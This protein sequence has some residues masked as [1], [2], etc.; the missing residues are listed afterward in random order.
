MLDDL[1]KVAIKE[2]IEND[3]QV[4]VDMTFKGL[5]SAAFLLSRIAK[6][7]NEDQRHDAINGMEA[8]VSA[9]IY[10][11]LMNGTVM[12]IKKIQDKDND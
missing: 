12:S 2:I 11:G 3:R 1:N 10:L 8:L 9:A 4:E 5:N 7:D 6:G